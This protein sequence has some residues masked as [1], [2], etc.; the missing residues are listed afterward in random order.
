MIL[1]QNTYTEF[2]WKIDLHNLMHFL[3]LRADKHAQKEI[4]LYAKAM[5]EIMRMW[6]PITHEAF[7]DYRINSINFS[8]NDLSSIKELI[9]Y[10]KVAKFIDNNAETKN[11]D[12]RE[13]LQKLKLIISA[14]N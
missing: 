7:C 11:G 1:P 4:Q 6:V 9:D 5:L 2:Y 12:T 3:R 13:L 14:K 8:G 10:D